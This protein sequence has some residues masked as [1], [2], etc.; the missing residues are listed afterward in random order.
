MTER[1]AK[2]LLSNLMGAVAEKF[3]YDTLFELSS[4]AGF[5]EKEMAE[6]GWMDEE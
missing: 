3:E 4:K 1:R 6:L 5:T 2:E